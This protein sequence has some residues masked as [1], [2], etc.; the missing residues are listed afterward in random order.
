METKRFNAP[1]IYADHHVMEARRI[2][3][4][5]EGVTDVYVS[6]A[7]RVIEVQFDSRKIQAAQIESRLQTAGYL[8]ELPI[9]AEPEVATGKS[10]ANGSFRHTTVYETLKGSVAFAQ[11]VKS[12]GRPLWPCPGFGA[13]EMEK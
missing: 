6:S 1:A 9:P 13:I 11:S 7:F 3:L 2:L 8:G 10:D 4:E 12:T 5:L